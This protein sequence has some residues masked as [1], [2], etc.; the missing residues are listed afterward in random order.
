MIRRNLL[1]VALVF[2]CACIGTT[3]RE[4]RNEEAYRLAARGE[5]AAAVAVIRGDI[6]GSTSTPLLL[7][8]SGWALACEQ[9][10][11]A[12]TWSG[13]VLGR[14]ATSLQAHRMHGLAQLGLGRSS[15]AIA[16]LEF[17]YAHGP[18][19]ASVQRAL[20]LA[21]EALGHEAQRAL[22]LLQLSRA[23]DSAVRAAIGRL[24]GKLS[25]AL[26]APSADPLSRVATCTELERELALCKFLL[27]LQQERA[28]ADDP[29]ATGARAE[30]RRA[31][32]RSLQ[33]LPADGA[34]AQTLKTFVEIGLLAPDQGRIDPT[35]VMMRGR[36]AR[37][38]AELVRI[39]EANR[40]LLTGD[41]GE[42]AFKDLSANHPDFA[43]AQLACSIG[44]MRARDDRRFAA[45][46]PLTERDMN[47]ALPALRVLLLASPLY[48]AQQEKKSP[49]PPSASPAAP[50]H[51]PSAATVDDPQQTPPKNQLTAEASGTGVGKSKDDAL[52]AAKRDALARAI[53]AMNQQEGLG[54]PTLAL[55]EALTGLEQSVKGLLATQVLDEKYADDTGLASVRVKVDADRDAFR[56]AANKKLRV[57]VLAEGPLAESIAHDLRDRVTASGFEL[58]P[59]KTE[60]DVDA[61]VKATSVVEAAPGEIGGFRAWRAHLNV[62]IVARS[63]RDGEVIQLAS[64][65]FGD[66]E[67]VHAATEDEVARKKVLPSVKAACD[68]VAARVV[69]ANTAARAVDVVVHDVKER[70]LVEDLLD[71][72]TKRGE[73]LGIVGVG[74]LKFEPPVA[75]IRL[76]VDRR[77]DRLG[78]AL[79]TIDL[80]SGR[81]LKVVAEGGGSVLV[82]IVAP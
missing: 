15:A 7:D 42:S 68:L 24:T 53:A 63:T 50:P 81:R 6:D 10:D 9:L 16:D 76:V 69:A 13:I 47:L 32:A 48:G 21:L 33:D 28:R 61:I 2:T 79:E 72:L 55:I 60:A 59:P 46:E 4:Y 29:W 73:K 45:E 43:S 54:E 75:V 30:E 27:A 41:A 26:P 49:P 22:A 58:T 80:S 11:L 12:E 57:Q 39:L 78:G 36:F 77:S 19:D 66:D 1:L 70:F 31:A 64:K 20:G 65:S 52:A 37:M 38:T 35:G 23:D 62:E 67:L 56:R 34:A 71:A 25:P 51:G 82:K 14:D 74:Q 8:A 44:V 3:T 5:A 40:P 18:A 17:A